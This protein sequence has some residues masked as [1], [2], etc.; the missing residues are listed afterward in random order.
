M[1]FTFSTASFS[2]L[3]MTACN[4]DQLIISRKSSSTASVCAR[5]EVQGVQ[6]LAGLKAYRALQ[7]SKEEDEVEVERN[8]SVPVP[9]T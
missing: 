6:H 2:L 1:S 7:F 5:T 4:V 8:T 3:T 9:L